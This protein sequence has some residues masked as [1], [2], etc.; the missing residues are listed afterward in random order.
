[1]SGGYLVRLAGEIE[2]VAPTIGWAS[3]A[4]GYRRAMAVSEDDHAVH[5]GFVIAELDPGGW[6]PWH[7]HSYRGELLRRH[8][9]GGRRHRRGIV[10]AP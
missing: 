3:S 2:L 6:I 4:T 7:V 5:T 8:G 9:Y 1:M 10:P